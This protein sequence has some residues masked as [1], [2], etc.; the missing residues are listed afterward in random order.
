VLVE[1][2]EERFE[3][4]IGR[5]PQISDHSLLASIPGQVVELRFGAARASSGVGT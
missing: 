1:L 2:V 3:F 5:R 4:G